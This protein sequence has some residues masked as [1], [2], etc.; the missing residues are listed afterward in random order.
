MQACCFHILSDGKIPLEHISLFSPFYEINGTWDNDNIAKKYT[1]NHE[2]LGWQ[3]FNTHLLYTMLPNGPKTRFIY[4][5]RNGRDVA[6]SFFHHLSN[7]LEGDRNSD[8]YAYMYIHVFLFMEVYHVHFFVST[9]L[10][11]HICIHTYI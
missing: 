5:I 2:L 9:Y 1:E 6:V 7:Q 4:V 10:Y 3:I 11:I 8:M